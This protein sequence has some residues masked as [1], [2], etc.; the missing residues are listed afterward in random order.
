MK[1]LLGILLALIICLMATTTIAAAPLV[2]VNN[3]G[4]GDYVIE[5]TQYW[6]WGIYYQQV[7]YV[8]PDSGL[9]KRYAGYECW[10]SGYLDHVT[11]LLVD[12]PEIYVDAFHPVENPDY[13]YPFVTTHQN[14]R[15]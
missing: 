3:D 11:G 1:R 6:S 14:K 7:F 15:K 10:R 13:T 8:Y 5:K 2:D 9:A 4:A 12:N